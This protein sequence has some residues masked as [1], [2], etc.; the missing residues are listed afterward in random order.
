M[1]GSYNKRLFFKAFKLTGSLEKQANRVV[2][3]IE[4]LPRGTMNGEREN[5]VVKE[6]TIKSKQCHAWANVHI[7][8]TTLPQEQANFVG[9]IMYEAT[10]W[11]KPDR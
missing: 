9:S 2:D 1:M 6:P 7:K 3:A 10:K 8:S 5:W 11:S 4:N